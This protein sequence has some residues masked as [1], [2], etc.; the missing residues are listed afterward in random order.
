MTDKSNGDL[1][2]TTLFGGVEIPETNVPTPTLISK[3]IERTAIEEGISYIDACLAFCEQSGMDPEDLAK[4]INQSL[5]EKMRVEAI[6]KNYL[7]K[8]GTLPL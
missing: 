3:R 6:E 7:K 2:M 8:E 4:M 5:R 1:N